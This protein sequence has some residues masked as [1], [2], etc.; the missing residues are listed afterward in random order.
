MT[1]VFASRARPLEASAIDDLLACPWSAL[2]ADAADLAAD[3]AL[4]AAGRAW[5]EL[6]GGPAAARAQGL[7][8]FD[9]V[10]PKAARPRRRARSLRKRRKP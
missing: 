2:V 6:P 8:A 10:G 9:G 1:A 4:A 5:R 7:A 3:A